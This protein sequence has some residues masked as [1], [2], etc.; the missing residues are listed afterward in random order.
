MAA[1]QSGTCLFRTSRTA[2]GRPPSLARAAG[3]GR[4]CR[5]GPTCS[6]PPTADTR[7]GRLGATSRRGRRCR[8]FQG[9]VYLDREILAGVKSEPVVEAFGDSGHA[10][11]MPGPREA[12]AA[13]SLTRSDWRRRCQLWHGATNS[14]HRR[15]VGP[16]FYLH[17]DVSCRFRSICDGDLLPDPGFEEPDP[18]HPETV[19]IELEGRRAVIGLQAY[20]LWL[21]AVDVDAER[22]EDSRVPP[23]QAVAKKFVGLHRAVA[24]RNRKEAVPLQHHALRDELLRA[25]HRA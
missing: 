4:G 7:L 8:G 20:R 13:G 12:N 19:C 17:D 9:D 1:P 15:E 10:C 21:L 23:P 6:L 25:D 2:C 16:N 5:C 22:G 11:R 14:Q 24:C 18:S 3:S